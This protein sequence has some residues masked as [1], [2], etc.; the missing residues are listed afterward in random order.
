MVRAGQ[1]EEVQN[2]PENSWLEPD[3]DNSLDPL[4]GFLP[5]LPDWPADP[6]EEEEE[7]RSDF[8]QG[9]GGR[10]RKAAFAMMMAWSVTIALHLSSW[11]T[12]MVW[13]LSAVVG[14][15]ILRVI[16]ARPQ[17][18]L[19]AA[20]SDATEQT[21]A[22][23]PDYPTFSLLVS[24]RNEEAVIGDLARQLCQLDYPRDRYEVWFVNDNSTDETGAILD[25]L[26]REYPQ[27]NVLHRS[28]ADGGGK[29]GALNQVLARTSGEFVA[30]FD[31]DAGVPKDILQRVLPLFAEPA[32]GAVQVRKAIANASE[33]IWTRGQ[34][35]EMVLD[36]YFQQQRIAVGGIG[37]LR[38]NG[39]FVRRS[40]LLRCGR[41]NEQTIT[42]DLD[43][44]L[45]LHLD[46]WRV[47]F[48]TYPAVGEEGV[49]SLGALWH[50]RNR[51]AEG[52]YQRY[53][54]YWRWIVRN[55]MG[56]NKTLDLL[57]FLLLQY[58]LPIA[59]IP[60]YLMALWRHHLPVLAP[61]SAIVFCFSSLGM[62]LGTRRVCRVEGLPTESLGV[63]C[64]RALLGFAYLT[65]WLV[66]IPAMAA[67]IAV[68]PKRLKWVKTAHQGN[69]APS[70]N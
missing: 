23:V 3:P 65:H 50:Q 61:L 68:R 32:T 20:A 45:R 46:T 27:L 15:H 70:V 22:A 52:G 37:E 36:S 60:D 35:I 64:T 5:E 17:I 2:L 62:I 4:A 57:T 58:L 8:F 53:L 38:G 42:D 54:D 31:A 34:E 33:N 28:A 18:L 13:L 51:W 43:L 24:A 59:A 49:A 44:T 55:P 39:Q 19:A 69:G 9:L 26:A 14:A 1:F 29:S 21:V 56:F 10:R 40:A 6:E 25:G 63:A 12:W 66:I 11:G 7:F 48:L 30:V 47:E 16:A 41:W 67:R